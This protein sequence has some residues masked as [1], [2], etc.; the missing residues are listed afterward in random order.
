[1]TPKTIPKSATLASQ[2]VSF[3]LSNSLSPSLSL[4][5]SLSLLLFSLSFATSRFFT[6]VAPFFNGLVIMFCCESK[7]IVVV[8]AN[9]RFLFSLFI[10]FSFLSFPLL[11]FSSR[12]PVVKGSVKAWKWT[13]VHPFPDRRSLWKIAAKRKTLTWRFGM[14]QFVFTL[15]LLFISASSTFAVFSLS[16]SF[17]FCVCDWNSWVTSRRVWSLTLSLSLCVCLP[18]PPVFRAYSQLWFVP[19]RLLSSSLFCCCKHSLSC[20]LLFSPSR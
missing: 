16:S 13:A 11:S 4:I 5:H 8:E 14:S 6:I 12:R 19:V 15:L 3:V 20:H 7:P 1:M 9:L 18:F 10:L 2:L 17:L